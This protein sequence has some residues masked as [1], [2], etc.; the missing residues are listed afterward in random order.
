MDLRLGDK[1]KVPK[2]LVIDHVGIYVGAVRLAE[3]T[4]IERAVVHNSKIHGRVVVTA[5]E[6]FAVNGQVEILQ[7]AMPGTESIVV[8]RAL[9]LLDRA[10]DL[11]D[12]NCEHAASLAQ[13]GVASS[14]QLAGWTFAT[15]ALLFG[16]LVGLA[17]TAAVRPRYDGRVGVRRDPRTG[18]FVGG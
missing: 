7:R 6:G 8:Q 15:G 18:R 2:D 12:F 17:R 5:L 9:D 13:T 3:G 10:Y 16:G 4:I 1:L 11:T 14:P